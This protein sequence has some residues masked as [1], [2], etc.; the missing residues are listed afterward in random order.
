[1]PIPFVNDVLVTA[2]ELNA[3]TRGYW[4]KTSEKDVTNT[5]TDTDLLNGE[6]TIDAGAMSTNRMVRVTIIGDYLNNTGAD[7]TFGFSLLFGGTVL[8]GE[9]VGGAAAGAIATS[10]T[11]RPMKIVAEIA[12]LGATNVQWS[13]LQLFLGDGAAAFTGI[14]DGSQ[15]GRATNNGGTNQFTQLGSAAAHALATT[16]SKLLEVRVSHSVASTS[17]S[18]RLK[19]GVVELV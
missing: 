1:M 4:R 13:S 7:R 8:I 19:F 10:A 17:L 5:V 11:R 2:A 15:I 9:S 12:N 6:I 16:T 18:A 14:G 3:L